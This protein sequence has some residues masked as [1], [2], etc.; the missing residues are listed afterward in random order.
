M[1]RFNPWRKI[2]SYHNI[3]EI[4]KKWRSRGK[5]IVFL[6]GFFDLFHVGHAAML[7]WAKTQGEVLVIGLGPDEA[8]RAWKGNG[9]PIYSQDDRAYILACHQ[10]VDY[11]LILEEPITPDRINF[12]EAFRLINPDLILAVSTD[13]PEMQSARK[14]MARELGAKLKIFKPF[15]HWQQTR[16]SASETVVNIKRYR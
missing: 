5:S 12:R 13:K 10:A 6:T 11:I 14:S 16:P 8:A 4:C 2:L 7:T 1:R 15:P 3:A 9:R